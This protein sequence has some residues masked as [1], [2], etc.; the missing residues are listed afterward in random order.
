MFDVGWLAV[1]EAGISLLEAEEDRRMAAEFP[2]K[3]AAWRAEK[4]RKRE[5]AAI[6]RKKD[7]RNDKLCDAIRSA[8]RMA[9]L[10]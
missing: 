10:R 1:M 7:D 6:E 3:Y 2:E 5:L 8:G 9:S 4:D